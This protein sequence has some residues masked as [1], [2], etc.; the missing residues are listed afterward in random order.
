MDSYEKILVVFLATALAILLSLSIVVLIKLIKLVN[1]VNRIS[2]KA[3][4][5]VERVADIG[6]VV[7]RFAGPF[8]FG[9]FA[10][11]KFKGKKAKRGNDA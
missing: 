6:A 1:R 2:E 3:E 9:K 5:A 4:S 8:M 10:S 7:Q 11:T